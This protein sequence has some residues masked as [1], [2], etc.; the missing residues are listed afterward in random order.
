MKK[1]LPRKLF[2]I[3]FAI[4]F[5]TSLFACGFD[6]N[7]DSISI[8]SESIATDNSND[9]S[10]LYSSYEPLDE[11][12][13]A[14]IPQ[15]TVELMVYDEVTN[16][17]GKQKGWFGQIVKDLFNVELVFISNSDQRRGADIKN[18]DFD[19]DIMIWGSNGEI[20]KMVG[21]DV[22]LDWEKNDCLS[23][24][25]PYIKENLKDNIEMNRVISGGG[26]YGIGYNTA[27][28]PNEYA[29]FEY[30][31]DVRWDLYQELGCPEVK[32][33]EDYVSVFKKMKEICPL[34][35]SGKETYAVSLFPDWD[36]DMVMYVKSTAT[37]YYGMDEF[38]CGL[39][40]PKTK[41]FH[42]ALEK[43]GPYLRCLRFYNTLYR[44]K[45]LNPESR[46]LT[47][48]D[49]YNSYV[50]GQT[51]SCIFSW[52]G[53]GAY[54]SSEHQAD[55]KLMAPL[56][57]K[58][59]RT[60]VYGL[61][62]TGDVYTWTIGAKTQ[63]P[64]LCMAIINWMATPDGFLT[65][66][67]GPKGVCWDYDSEGNTMLLKE[68]YEATVHPEYVFDGSTGYEGGFQDGFCYFN[69]NIWA[70]DTVNPA[71]NGQTFNT[72][73]WPNMSENQK[74]Y[75]VMNDWLE[76]YG[77]A[78]DDEYMR[79]FS[80]TIC[81]PNTFVRTEMSETM[82]ENYPNLTALIRERSWDAIYAETEEEFDSIVNQFI[83]EAEQYDYSSIVEFCEAEAAKRAA[84]EV[85]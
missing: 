53:A 59:Q 85:Y 66:L 42:G 13:K 46:T 73:T 38:Y 76:Y 37:N 17:N 41:I 70:K 10:T 52:L 78:M 35:D 27:Y 81:P 68:G 57:C 6:G 62:T 22:L 21:K 39:Y 48:D 14:I 77:V 75:D 19:C 67:Y 60:L 82:N 18:G 31:P 43:S 8:S 63:Y 7:T 49:V 24:Y 84:S 28:G 33:L 32:D 51:F 79:K 44:E 9:I 12:T 34:S 74:N 20:K 55:G 30:H 61:N 58:N 56:A 80:V 36:G 45:L 16:K 15:E 1:I 23:K 47:Y 26:V 4:I 72:K 54:N 5:S 11:A 64:E 2:A 25:G 65:S 3:T 71:S 83:E 50:D 69:C 40:D 29:G